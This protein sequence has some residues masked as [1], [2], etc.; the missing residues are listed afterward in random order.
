MLGM[1]KFVLYAFIYLF[2][3][4]ANLLIKLVSFKKLVRL[5]SNATEEHRPE[6]TPKMRGRLNTVKR[7]VFSVS[8]R[9][10][11][12]SNCFEQ[13]LTASFLLKVLGVSHRIY[14]GLNNEDNQLKA[15]A[16]LMVHEQYITGFSTNMEF[17][18][19]SAF[20]YTSKKDRVHYV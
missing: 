15:H 5:I 6:L 12:R 17:T 8:R 4:V 3:G 20:Y 18:A 1:K 11:W 19:V 10:P 13:A 2:L 7:A 9:T 14:F 16:W